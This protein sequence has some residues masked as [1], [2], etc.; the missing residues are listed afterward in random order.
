LIDTHS[1]HI[2]ILLNKIEKKKE[3][4]KEKKGEE[5]GASL[6]NGGVEGREGKL[7]VVQRRELGEEVVVVGQHLIAELRG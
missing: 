6:A 1:C 2:N 4:R 7:S 3:K 5:V